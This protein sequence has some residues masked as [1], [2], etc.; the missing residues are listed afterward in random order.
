MSM[1]SITSSRRTPDFAAAFSK[2]YR[3][4]TTMSIGAIP[5]F[6]AA[7]RCSALPRRCRMPPCTLG[8]SVFTRPSN[9]SGKPVS[10]D[11]S[12][13]ARPASRRAFAVP[14]VE[15]SSTPNPASTRAKSTRPVLSVTLSSARLIFFS[16]LKVVLRNCRRDE[17]L[18][19]NCKHKPPPLSDAGL[20]V[21][22]SRRP[23]STLSSPPFVTAPTER[24]VRTMHAF[25][26]GERRH[27]PQP[28]I[29]P[30]GAWD[31]P[32]PA[33]EPR[34]W[35]PPPQPP[36]RPQRPQRRH[37]ASA[38]ATYWLVGINFAVYR[39]EEHTSELQSP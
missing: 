7:A 19:K 2:A 22:E 12:R 10:S 33:E 23:R 5:C 32:Q 8:C 3:F 24:Y 17:G 21:E 29:L 15:T 34:G 38:P 11:T 26:D 31:E 13:T 1:F 39:S 36:P 16:P 30:P 25:S 35:Y 9:I 6:A 18:Q 4:T 20:S 27:A 37:W 28:E 14:P